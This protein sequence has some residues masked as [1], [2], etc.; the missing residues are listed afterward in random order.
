ML[1]QAQCARFRAELLNAMDRLDKERRLIREESRQP[2]NGETSGGIS[3][4]PVHPGDLGSH[5]AEEVTDLRLME[6][7][8]SLMREIC[9]ALDRIEGGTFGRCEFCHEDI[10]KRRLNVVPYS[11][12]C[13]RCATANEQAT[14]A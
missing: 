1:N 11:R 3:S 5:E 6:N 9:D 13:L 10:P 14:K 4:V 8:E 12:F 7:A 2:S